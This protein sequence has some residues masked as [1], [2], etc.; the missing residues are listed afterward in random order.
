M[1]L[2]SFAHTFIP[3]ERA[4]EKPLLLLHRTGVSE[5]V[6]IPWARKL[7][8]GAALLAVRGR[9][10]EDG[11]PR[12]FRRLGQAQ[13]DVE[14]LLIQT[15]MLGRFIEAAREQY[16]LEA[17]IAVGHSNGANIAWSLMFARP[18][19]LSGA[20]LIR[21]LMPI[22]PAEVGMMHKFP[23]LI[24]SGSEDRVA[25][26]ESATAL[27]ELLRTAGATVSHV[28]LRAEHD[29]VSEDFEFAQAWLHSHF[30]PG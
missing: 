10:L 19:A 27:P 17:P 21:P 4:S 3:A 6:L 5:S 24:L 13:F 8:P 18:S 29:L 9:V 1:S 20:V 11:K 14:D 7:C 15:D 28:F 16:R 26:P 30:A 22:K 23:V 12:F 2:D 25:T